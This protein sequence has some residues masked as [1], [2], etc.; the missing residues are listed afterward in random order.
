MTDRVTDPGP[1][2]AA[3]AAIIIPHYNDVVRLA[4]CLRALLP[5]IR[6][7]E[8]LVVVDNGSTQDLAPHSAGSRAH[9]WKASRPPRRG[10]RS[11]RPR[12]RR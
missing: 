11:W 3:E 9:C 4:R 7:G 6:P 10:S 5:Q 12:V 1:D 8:E 2:P